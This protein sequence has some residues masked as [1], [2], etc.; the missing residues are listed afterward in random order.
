[1]PL[2]DYAGNKVLDHLIGETTFAK[3]TVHLGLLEIRAPS[4]LLRSTAVS[5][6]DFTVPATPNGRLYRC[7]TAGTT[8]AGEPSWPTTDG[9][10]V[11]DGGAVWTEHTP[12][13]Q[14]QV[15]VPEMGYT[16]YGRIAAA[17]KWAAAANQ[18]ASNNANLEWP[19]KTAGTDE[20]YGGV[21]IYD[22]SSGGNLIEWVMIVPPGLPKL[23]ENGDSPRI[24]T[25][26]L[27]RTSR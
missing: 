20:W 25:G 21:L 10:T 15:N 3:P 23:I 7:T 9:G 14:D 13:L 26:D 27:D 12:S 8:D 17:G 4:N 24:L 22:A 1:M 16:G 11:T 6:G 5:V 2:T 19:V 18:A